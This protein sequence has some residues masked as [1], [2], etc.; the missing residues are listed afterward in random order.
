MTMY[1][2]RPG[3]GHKP[4]NTNLSP[5]IDPRLAFLARAAARFELVEACAMSLDEAYNGLFE[6]KRPRAAS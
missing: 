3:T 2:A 6:R 4:N 5:P 1:L